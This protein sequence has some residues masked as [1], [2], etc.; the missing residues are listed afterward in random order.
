M[1]IQMFHYTEAT[2][3]QELTLSISRQINTSF[4]VS[5]PCYAVCVALHPMTA[6][7]R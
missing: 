1:T 6:T 3:N 7:L 2:G 4:E 5:Y